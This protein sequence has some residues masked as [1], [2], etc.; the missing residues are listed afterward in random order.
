VSPLITAWSGFVVRRRSAVISFT[1]I[2]LLLSAFSTRNLHT[3]HSQEVW[4]AP[5]EPAQ[6]DY[7]RLT[8]LFGDNEYLLIGIGARAADRDIFTADGFRLLY[9]IT[10][11]LEQ[12]PVVSNVRSLIRYR[13]L[14]RRGDLTYVVP[15]APYL[16]EEFDAGDDALERARN[17]VKADGFVQGAL[18]TQDLRHTLIMARVKYQSGQK[19]NHITLMED[20]RRL[21]AD[22]LLDRQGFELHFFGPPAISQAFQKASAGDQQLSFPLMLLVI[23]TILFLTFRSL[24]GVLLPTAVVLGALLL[25]GGMLSLL[26][27]PITLLNASLIVILMAI[28]VS[29]AIHVMVEYYLARDLGQDARRAAATSAERLFI[30]CL[31]TS[32]TTM[33]GFLAIAVSDLMP[34]REFGIIAAW[35]VGI[36]FLLTFTLLPALLSYGGEAPA[37]S[38]KI[39][40]DNPINRLLQHL[41]RQVLGRRYGIILLSGSLTLV[42]LLGATTIRIDTNVLRFFKD[43][44]ELSRDAQYFSR[45]YAYGGFVEYIVDAGTGSG[46][47]A[48]DPV[49]LRR[50]RAFQDWLEKQPES[51]ATFSL[52]DTIARLHTAAKPEE[53]PEAG[54]PDSPERL[55]K[56]INFYSIFGGGEDLAELISAD[57]R[58]VRIS[59]RVEFLS[60]ADLLAFI[61][62]V[63]AHQAGEFPEMTM[64]VTGVPVLFAAIN[65]HINGGIADAIALGM[66]M[67]GACLLALL[68]SWKLGL[69]ALLPA[70][71]SMVVAAGVMGTAGITLNFAA[72][73]IISV[74][75]GIAV[76]N[77]IH[78]VSRY[79]AHRK[80][81]EESFPAMEQAVRESGRALSY[82]ALVLFLGFAILT[83]SNMVPNIQLGFFA[84]LILLLALAA[85][86]TLLPALIFAL[87]RDQRPPPQ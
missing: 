8:E 58:Y 69:L 29:D 73:V 34:I 82:S 5:D 64:T 20:L 83:T 13:S 6:R 67:V 18:I 45:H 57:D 50:V 28:G 81:G 10:G 15:L 70:L 26:G 47:P 86:L 60:S 41:T 21:T 75:F 38:R 16:P 32:L 1:L 17:L 85:S 27:W 54:I 65:Q 12:H 9:A 80:Q 56:Y 11:F 31:Y 68:R 62:R 53:H 87:G 40:R 66:A 84:A 71:L 25:S 46:E 24:L 76:D 33:L 79:A 19:D 22:K 30:P 63:K 36:A 43:D 49:F 2:L 59:Q 44:S 7:Q 74:T 78:I 3:D 48:I 72:M 14:E 37:A 39:I 23:A 35:G 61:G 55:K 42:A 4:L 77:A 51:G 52:A